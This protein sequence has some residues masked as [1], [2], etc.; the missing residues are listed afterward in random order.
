MRYAP[1]R[2]PAP[3][4][5]ARAVGDFVLT[6]TRYGRDAALST[7]AHEYSCLVIVLDGD[8]EEQFE[9]QTRAAGPGT[10]I[11]RP[12]GERHSD[13]FG[14]GGGRCLNVELGPQWLGRVREAAGP[15]DRS[16]AYRS[17][18]FALLGRRLHAELVTVD[19][20]SPLTVESL[21]LELFGDAAREERC[22]TE[23]APRWLL[24]AKERIDDDATAPVTLTAL[25]AE[26]GVHPVHLAT[27]F[28]RCF[29]RTVATYVRQVRVEL[30]C[31]Q[32][33]DTD[34]PLADIALTAGF[35]DQSHFGR[36]FKQALGVTPAVYRAA[37]RRASS[38]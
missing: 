18:A 21:V 5:R 16:S 7:H 24:R 37:M 13:R 30:A 25:A 35:S 15:L 19:A 28:R 9:G 34:A 11:L 17:A 29:G 22:R 1:T 3:I 8:F 26:A 33:L 14:R 36:R 23:S 31:R 32:L 4:V 10:V 12:E 2:F 6:E 20:L 27:T 38:P